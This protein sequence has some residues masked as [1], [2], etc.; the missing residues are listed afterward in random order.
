MLT[1]LGQILQPRPGHHVIGPTVTITWLDL[2]AF[3][4]V[5]LDVGV[6]IAVPSATIVIVGRAQIQLPPVVQIRLDVVGVIDPGRSLIAID[7]ALVDSHLLGIFSVTGTAAVRMAWGDR[8]HL[9]IT[10]GG[11]YPGFHP[12]PALLPPQQRLGLHL[13]IP[14]PLTFRADGYLAITANTVQAGAYVEAGFDLD[15]ISAHGAIKFDSIVTFDPFHIHADFS[16]E[17]HVVAA[18]FE[19]GTTVSG[20]IDGPGPW[21]IHARVSVSLLFDD[22]DWSNT[23]T[24]GPPGPPERPAFDRITEALERH[25]DVPSRFAAAS[26]ADPLVQVVERSGVSGVAG[27]VVASPLADLTWTQDV[28]PLDLPV[29]RAGGQ[30]LAF[31]QSV[32]VAILGAVRDHGPATGWFAPT[33]FTDL[34]DAEA[35][36]QPTYQ[37]LPAGRRL[38]LA[39]SSEGIAT[40]TLEYTEHFKTLQGVRGPNGAP[41]PFLRFDQAVLQCIADQGA[42]AKVG[43]L[44][45]VVKVSDEV[46]AVT[47]NGNP[48][49]PQVSAIHALTATRRSGGILHALADRP[50][51]VVAL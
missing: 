3:S 8:P 37:S 24:F 28:V 48:P 20:W 44:T 46:W 10:V 2:G 17:W 33:V 27:A 5:R 23:F 13:A 6:L 18:I 12:E 34:T 45:S 39:A 21:K 36:G 7:A 16:A 40:A 1:T 51:T 22:F 47:H 38:T 26:A 29:R 14:C 43:D 31:E 11:F 19:G 30:R 9:V 32:S 42:V 49:Q 35:L 50:I 15:I 4:I 25:L 41:K